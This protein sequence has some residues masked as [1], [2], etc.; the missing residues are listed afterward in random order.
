[1]LWVSPPQNGGAGGKPGDCVIRTKA[2]GSSPGGGVKWALMDMHDTGLCTRLQVPH[3][4]ALQGEA[5]E[6]QTREA[7]LQWQELMVWDRQVCAGAAEQGPQGGEP[8]QG[9]LVEGWLKGEEKSRCVAAKGAQRAS[10]QCGHSC[11]AHLEAWGLQRGK[12]AVGK[13]LSLPAYEAWLNLCTQSPQCWPWRPVQR[14]P[15]DVLRHRGV[16]W[17]RI[18]EL[19]GVP[20][21]LP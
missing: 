5:W 6:V 4:L 9:M 18:P 3:L 17:A 1:M 7:G 11:R 19:S 16:S 14:H 12:G 21:G 15:L 8:A 20:L 13:G 2:A 10:A